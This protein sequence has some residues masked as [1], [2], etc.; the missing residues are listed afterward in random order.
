MLRPRLVGFLIV[1]AALSMPA[2]ARAQTQDFFQLNYFDNANNPWAPDQFVRITSPGTSA[3]D[4]CAMIYVFRPD[5]QLAECCGCKVTPNA[6]LKLSVNRNLTSNPLTS[7]PFTAGVVKIISSLQTATPG[8]VGSSKTCNPAAPVV[9][10]ALRAWGT[11]LDDSGAITETEFLNAT[12]SGAELS[13][14]AIPC[15]V[16]TGALLPPGL[17]SGSGVCDCTNLLTGTKEP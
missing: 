16:I 1:V 5:Q 7:D 13:R 12:L 8:P 11:H 2:I 3:A 4:L 14:T 15:G 6:L 10:A 17:G 9:T